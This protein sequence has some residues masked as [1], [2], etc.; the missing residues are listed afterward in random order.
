MSGNARSAFFMTEPAD[1]GGAGSD[2]SARHKGFQEARL[3][4]GASDLAEQIHI[5]FIGRH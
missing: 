1:A 4:L 2:P 5:A 3:L